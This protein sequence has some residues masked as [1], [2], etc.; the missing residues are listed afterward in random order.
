[1]ALKDDGVCL[2]LPLSDQRPASCHSEMVGRVYY[3]G[4]PRERGRFGNYAPSSPISAAPYRPCVTISG[5]N[6]SRLGDRNVR[7]LG[8]WKLPLHTEPA[9]DVGAALPGQAS[10]S[11][12]LLVSIVIIRTEPRLASTQ[13]GN[14]RPPPKPNTPQTTYVRSTRRW[15]FYGERTTVVVVVGAI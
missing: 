15:I 8:P 10:H 5:M 12:V 11:F 4:L 2:F 3:S 14:S 6:H 13:A 9:R 7:G 1:M